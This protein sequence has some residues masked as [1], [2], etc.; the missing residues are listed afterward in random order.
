MHIALLIL[1]IKTYPDQDVCVCVCVCICWV[2][3]WP[4]LINSITQ[5]D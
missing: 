2:I 1:R 4:Q 3:N 5:V